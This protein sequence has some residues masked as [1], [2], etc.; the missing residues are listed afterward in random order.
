[1]KSLPLNIT[2]CFF[3]KIVLLNISNLWRKIMMVLFC[4]V[5]AWISG[6]DTIDSRDMLC[7]TC[8][9][10]KAKIARLKQS[11]FSLSWIDTVYDTVK[12]LWKPWG[13]VRQQEP[14]QLYL[15]RYQLMRSHGWLNILLNSYIPYSTKF[16]WGKF[17]LILILQIFDGKYFDGW[18]LS[19]T[20]HL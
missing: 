13:K 17:W 2:K 11:T 4:Q 9:V 18:S 6:Q 8:A 19:F 5:E 3:I 7:F 15:V 16:W 14:L 10:T 20:I 12:S 1:M